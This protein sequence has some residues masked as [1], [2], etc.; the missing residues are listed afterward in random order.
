LL[1]SVILVLMTSSSF[2]GVN[3]SNIVRDFVMNQGETE[4]PVLLALKSLALALESTPVNLDILAKECEVIKTQC[5]ID[6]AHRCLAGKNDAYGTLMSALEKTDDVSSHKAILSALCSLCNGQPDLLEDTGRRG[7]LARIKTQQDPGLIFLMVHF[8]RY[9][10]IKHEA[11]RRAYVNDDLIQILSDLLDQYKNE[12]SIVKEACST[13][14]VLTFDDDIRVPF[15]SSHDHAKLIVTRAGALR[16]IMEM[17]KG[18]FTKII[19]DHGASVLS[20]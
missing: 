17:C 8:I 1:D 14:R 20:V 3:L 11:N 9:T 15:C 4:H 10:C 13:F 12:A 2:Q 5:D 19:V 18:L 16:R 7:I 6:L